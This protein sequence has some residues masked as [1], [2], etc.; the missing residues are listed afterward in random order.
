MPD[1]DMF[2]MIF[3]GCHI[4]AIIRASQARDAGPT[5]V[6]RLTKPHHQLEREEI[7]KVIYKSIKRKSVRLFL[8]T[9][10]T[11]LFSSCST[12]SPKQIVENVTET[13]IEGS[14]LVFKDSNWLANGDGHQWF[15]FEF[16]DENAKLF[17][18]RIK[19]AGT[20]NPLPFPSYIEEL[21][22]AFGSSSF[23]PNTENGWWCVVDY[24]NPEELRHD[25]SKIWTKERF[26]VDFNFVIYDANTHKLYLHGCFS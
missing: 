21:I 20:W 10:I 14:K 9:V 13:S 17:E 6:N 8:I 23:F 4:T 18:E 5:P 11:I 1:F 2:Y 15:I 3:C 16:D 19:E 25:G 26:S 12:T 24:Q 7:P 22:Q